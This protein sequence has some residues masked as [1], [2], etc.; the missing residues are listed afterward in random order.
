MIYDLT[1]INDDDDDDDDTDDEDKEDHDDDEEEEEEHLALADSSG[2]PIMDP[3]P[4]AGDTE[5]F[6]T[7]ELE[8]PMSASM[9]VCIARHAAVLTPSLP[10]PSPPLP[11]PSPLTTSPTNARGTLGYRAAEIRMRALLTSTSCRTNI[12]KADMPPRKRAC[13]TIL[14]LGFKVGES[15]AAGDDQALLRARV[16]TLFKDRSDNRRTTMLLDREAMYAHEAWPDYKDMSTA[17]EAHVRILE[18]HVA[19]LIAHTSSLQT[20]LTTSLGRFEILEARDLEPQ[21]G[22]AEAGSGS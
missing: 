5:T 1:Y 9:E 22:P 8:P 21:E 15:S 3:V 16:N 14:A 18:A 12:P 11:L 10:V 13:V 6:E 2:V 4:P 19:T 17:I 20:Q 7:D